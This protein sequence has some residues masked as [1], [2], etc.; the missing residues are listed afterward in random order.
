M[1]RLLVLILLLAIEVLI[2]VLVVDPVLELSNIL[3]E[4]IHGVQVHIHAH[5]RL[6]L[7]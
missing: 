6:F 5:S 3:V 4:L 7:I 1:G 2:L